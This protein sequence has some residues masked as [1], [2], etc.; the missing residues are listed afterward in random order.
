MAGFFIPDTRFEMPSLLEPGRKPVGP[1]IFKDSIP[2][3]TFAY[4]PGIT[5]QGSI[6]QNGSLKHQ[7]SEFGNPVS[8]VFKGKRAE[9]FDTTSDCHEWNANNFF[10]N[11]FFPDVT[12]IS[13]VQFIGTGTGFRDIVITQESGE[14]T[15]NDIG[16]LL[17]IS[18]M[19][20]V[21][22]WEVNGA[23][24]Y[25][26]SDGSTLSAN[27]WYTIAVKRQGTTVKFFVDGIQHG[28]TLTGFTSAVVGQSTDT[29]LTIGASYVQSQELDGYLDAVTVL[30]GAL[31]DSYIRQISNDYYNEIFE[32]K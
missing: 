24:Q 6:L 5:P 9:H 27:V 18:L 20:P 21:M 25:A 17:G 13:I 4:I 15:A 11:G 3:N 28:S 2:K 23:N 19:K 26:L 16:Y 14:S 29:Q 12:I 30:P 1:V 10:L 7:D 22:F 32:P 31:S 8:S